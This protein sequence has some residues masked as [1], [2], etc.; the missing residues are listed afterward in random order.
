MSFE[1][2]M[3]LRQHK[4]NVAEAFHWI[5]ENIPEVLKEEEQYHYE[6]Q[7]CFDHDTSKDRFDE[8]KAYDDYFYG[9]NRSYAVVEAFRVAW[10]MH[11]HRNPHHW[12]H[13]VLMNDDPNEGEVVMDMPYNYIVEM[14][15]D[16][17][18]FALAK[19]RPIEVCEFYSQ[20]AG[21]M[22]MS[23]NTRREVEAILDKIKAKL[24]SE[25][26][27]DNEIDAGDDADNGDVS[28]VAKVAE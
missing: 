15:C 3:Y 2:D 19:G 1:Y 11:I 18:S 10:L 5:R 13:W 4:E 28:E 7:I 24:L 21:Y 27:E 22:K 26:T 6:H 8:Y 23:D 14:V 16:W 9:G 12:Q 17:M 25:D 20:H